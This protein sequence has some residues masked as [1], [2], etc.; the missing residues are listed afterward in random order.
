VRLGAPLY[1]HG[2][3]KS[4]FADR[5]PLAT[6]FRSCSSSHISPLFSLLYVL[7]SL[8][9]VQLLELPAT[10]YSS[11]LDFVQEVTEIHGGQLKN[12]LSLLSDRVA[13]LLVTLSPVHPGW[14]AIRPSA[15]SVLTVLT[16][17][18]WS[19]LSNSRLLVVDSRI[20]T[21]T[22]RC[23]PDRE[24]W[25]RITA[26]LLPSDQSGRFFT[27]HLSISSANARISLTVSSS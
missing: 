9:V 17:R 11:R 21:S 3:S 25:K 16:K 7:C 4:G 6:S 22:W 19:I 24:I 5:R 18:L 12:E 2:R 13:D 8:R 27:G 15:S 26:A 10:F 20:A 1:R 23:R 14:W